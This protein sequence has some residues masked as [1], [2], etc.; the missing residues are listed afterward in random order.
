[1]EHKTRYIGPGAAR[2]F[3]RALTAAGVATALGAARLAAQGIDAQVGRFYEDAGWDVYRLGVNRPVLGV[4]GLGLQ[5]NYLRRAD[6]GDGGFAG[7][8]ADV[9]AFKGGRQGPYLVAGIG[10]GMGS[11]QSGDFNTFWGSWSA[12]AGYELFPVSFL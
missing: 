7:I 5:G 10:G 1:M 2:C 3:G 12:G 8:S 4:L 11:P 9:T 6:G